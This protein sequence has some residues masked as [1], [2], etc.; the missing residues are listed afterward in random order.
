MS[1]ISANSES[2]SAVQ[3]LVATSITLTMTPCVL[4]DPAE[5]FPDRELWPHSPPTCGFVFA[6]AFVLV[7][8]ADAN[9]RLAAITLLSAGL[10]YFT[11][12]NPIW[13]LLGAGVVGAFGVFGG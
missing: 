7:R 9:W 8:A 11:K 13:W 2:L 1:A 10:A 5:R 12:L 4:I 3:S 6:S